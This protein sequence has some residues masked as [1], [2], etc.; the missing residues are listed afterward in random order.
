MEYYE[1]ACSKCGHRWRWTGYKTGIGKTAAQLEEMSKAGKTCPRCGG[2][3]KVG[4]DMTSEPAQA[5]N[6]AVENMFAPLFRKVTPEPEPPPNN[7]GNPVMEVLHS[8]LVRA[9]PQSGYKSKCLRC[10]KGMLLVRRDLDKFE[11]HAEDNCILCGQRYKYL[12]IEALR[13]GP[14]S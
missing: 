10:E 3:A 5:F 12:D 13:K 14:G 11:L 4:L 1:S 9:S 2:E 7:F 6:K 8:S